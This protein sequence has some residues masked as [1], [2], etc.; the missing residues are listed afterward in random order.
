MT[1]DSGIH[2]MMEH[3]FSEPCKT[4]SG[5]KS[6]NGNTFYDRSKIQ[7][8]SN[9]DERDEEVENYPILCASK[10]QEWYS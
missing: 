6:K 4:S 5:A 9:D 3:H 7:G 1:N 10:E 8:A 2:M